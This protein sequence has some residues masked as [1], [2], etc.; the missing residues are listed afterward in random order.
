M[1]HDYEDN[2]V[3]IIDKIYY[4][5]YDRSVVFDKEKIQKHG[6]VP[7]SIDGHKPCSTDKLFESKNTCK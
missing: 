5:V 1:T 3:K 6:Y 4:V 2:T 7:F